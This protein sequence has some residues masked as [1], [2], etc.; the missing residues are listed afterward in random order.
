MRARVTLWRS[1][2]RY[3][4]ATVCTTLRSANRTSYTL[5]VAASSST[6]VRP[7]CGRPASHVDMNGGGSLAPDSSSSESVG[8]FRRHERRRN[9]G[10]RPVHVLRVRSTA[11]VVVVHGTPVAR[12]HA[13][14]A[15]QHRPDRLE[16]RYESGIDDSDTAVRARELLR[17]EVRRERAAFPG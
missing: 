17:V 7:I 11:D 5:P 8:R 9:V 3:A 2:A 14:R 10:R 1:A 15:S 16:Q 6:S 13:Y 12:E 4:N